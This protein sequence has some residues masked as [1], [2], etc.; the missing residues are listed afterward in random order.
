MREV[1]EEKDFKQRINSYEKY[2]H[3]LALE[4]NTQEREA[5]KKIG[6]AHV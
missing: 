1:F 2:C 3:E 4:E 6:R 5:E